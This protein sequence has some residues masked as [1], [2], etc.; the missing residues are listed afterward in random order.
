MS[1]NEMSEVVAAEAGRSARGPRTYDGAVLPVAGVGSG[2]ERLL[3]LVARLWRAAEDWV[4]EAEDLSR[5]DV[6]DIARRVERV[7]MVARDSR[8]PDWDQLGREVVSLEE[9]MGAGRTPEAIRKTLEALKAEASRLR[10]EAPVKVDVGAVVREA[11][12]KLPGEASKTEASAADKGG[13]A[14]AWVLAVLAVVMTVVV[15][16]WLRNDAV[17]AAHR[18]LALPTV[19]APPPEVGAQSGKA[20]E[21]AGR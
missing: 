7:R 8:G 4:V 21:R 10:L 1:P 18:S 14:T 5:R 16:M 11:F 13:F 19:E 3:V 6:L 15:A 20:N 12:A 2:R 9:Q 17:D